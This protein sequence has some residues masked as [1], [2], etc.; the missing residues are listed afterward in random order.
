MVRRGGPVGGVGLTNAN[1]ESVQNRF[2][3]IVGSTHP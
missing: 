3:F 2:I 1:V